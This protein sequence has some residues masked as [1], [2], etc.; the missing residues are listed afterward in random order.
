MTKRAAGA[1]SGH[2]AFA[3][4][5][6]RRVIRGDLALPFSLSHITSASSPLHHRIYTQHIYTMQAI[7]K[8]LSSNE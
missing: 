3:K 6:I 4:P 1:K 5:H 7:K 2:D 8:V